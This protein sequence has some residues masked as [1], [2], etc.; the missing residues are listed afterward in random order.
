MNGNAKRLALE[1]LLC[2]P[3]W[4]PA[5]RRLVR[6]V[7]SYAAL[8]QRGNEFTGRCP[9][10][11]CGGWLCVSPVRNC[12]KCFDCE[13]KHDAVT[14]VM[15]MEG[16]DRKRAVK[17]LCCRVW[18]PIEPIAFERRAVLPRKKPPRKKRLTV[19]CGAKNRKG[20]PC[21]RKLL[22][23]GG[24]CPNHG[25]RSTG[26]KTPEGKAR[27]VAQLRPYQKG[28]VHSAAD[29]A[30]RVA[31]LARNKAKRMALKQSLAK[32]PP[33]IGSRLGPMEKLRRL[34]AS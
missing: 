18:N 8:V 26:P 16:L 13:A 15:A 29:I 17:R 34:I 23:R 19:I 1:A 24:K 32:P 6:V 12:A 28:H 7:A 21:Q 27:S 10:P 14:F 25:G 5:G 9:L 30:A 31:S 2:E 33:R 20:E 11:G 4:T 3:E 22:L